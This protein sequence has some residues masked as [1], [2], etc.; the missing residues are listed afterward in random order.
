MRLAPGLMAFMPV[1]A[2]VVRG[3]EGKIFQPDSV[4]LYGYTVGDETRA[5]SFVAVQKTAFNGGRCKIS[6]HTL[7]SGGV[8]IADD[9]SGGRSHPNERQVGG[10]EF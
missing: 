9:A 10:E 5:G 2:N 6:S 1:S 3:H 4:N 8:T 7:I